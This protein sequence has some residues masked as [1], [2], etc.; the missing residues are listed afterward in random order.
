MRSGFL[1]SESFYNQRPSEKDTSKIGMAR[2]MHW[3]GLG[4]RLHQ[5]VQVWPNLSQS[6]AHPFLEAPARSHRLTQDYGEYFHMTARFPGIQ[7]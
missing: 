3:A 7:I 5:S 1:I 6:Q 4:H 2:D